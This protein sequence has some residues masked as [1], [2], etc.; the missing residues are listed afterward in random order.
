MFFFCNRNMAVDCNRIFGLSALT[1]LLLI[2]SVHLSYSCNEQV[3]AS[4]V[5]KCMLT[6]SCKCDSK[7]YSC[8]TECFKCLGH[9]Q[10]ECCSCLGKIQTESSSSIWVYMWLTECHNS[11]LE[12]CPKPTETRNVSRQSHVED[13]EGIPGLFKALTEEE[14]EDEDKWKTFTFPVDFQTVLVSPK[15]DK[16]FKYILRMF[17]I[18]WIKVIDVNSNKIFWIL[19]IFFCRIGWSN[20]RHIAEE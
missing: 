7:N 4:I 9:L 1:A 2:V 17:Q 5:S 13:L 20:F 19:F 8:C 14:D 10:L 11:L 18:Y 15:G 12:M 6:Q 3:C 16:P